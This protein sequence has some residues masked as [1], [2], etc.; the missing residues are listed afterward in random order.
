MKSGEILRR[1][2]AK[3]GR[4]IILRT[5]KWEDLDDLMELINSLIEEG[6]DI[7]YDTK[8]TREEE[9][10]WLSRAI[11]QLE[12]GNTLHMV[13]EVAGKVIASSSVGKRRSGCE[14]H[15]GDIGLLIRSGHRDVGIGTEMMKT[16]IDQARMMGL[17]VLVLS[18]FATNE[19][20]I[21][22]YKKVGFRE[23]GR[24][25]RSIYR[26]G[27]YIDRVMMAKEL[28]L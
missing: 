3:D 12:K 27:R 5:P 25:P 28:L 19:R 21:H 23:V 9:V 11:A 13:A 7:E 24:I 20:A 8:K 22:V 18:V 6:A 4:E 14:N 1:L 16:L 2:T 17:K 26:N 10:D 15:V